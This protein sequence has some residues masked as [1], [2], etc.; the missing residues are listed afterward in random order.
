MALLFV[1]AEIGAS[2][3]GLVAALE[4]A[5]IGSLSGVCADVCCQVASPCE[6]FGASLERARK[7]L[8][9]RMG[10]D[11]AAQIGV[12]RKSVV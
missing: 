7:W 5:H 1:S 9:S 11:M 4:G 6:S 2:G 12:V 10:P 3:E 8:L